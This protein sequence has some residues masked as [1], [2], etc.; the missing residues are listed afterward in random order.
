MSRDRLTAQ[1]VLHPNARVVWITLLLSGTVVAFSSL[2]VLP[3]NGRLLAPVG[4]LTLLLAVLI[5]KSPFN[6]LLVLLFVMLTTWLSQIRLLG[7]WLSPTPMIGA[8]VLVSWALRVLQRK[9]PFDFKREYWLLILF[10]ALGLLETVASVYRSD[11]AQ[12]F[13]TYLQLVLIVVLIVNLADTPGKLRQIGWVL[14]GAAF[15]LSA[16]IVLDELGWLSGGLVSQIIGERLSGETQGTLR[17]AGAWGDP[18]FTALQISLGLAFAFEFLISSRN[19]LRR[20]LLLAGIVMSIGVIVLTYSMGGLLG[21]IVMALARLALIWHA[22]SLRRRWGM[23]LLI[24]S[25]AIGLIVFSPADYRERIQEKF[26]DTTEILAAPTA[27]SLLYLGTKRGAAW[28]AA[29]T[30]LSEHPLGV[31][32]GVSQFYLMA[33]DPLG[34]LA[35][36]LYSHNA[37]LAIAVEFG[38]LGLLIFLGLL[39]RV[40]GQLRIKPPASSPDLRVMQHAL[41]VTWSGFLVQSMLLNAE[42]FKGTWI[43]LGLTLAYGD[44]A[45]SCS[46]VSAEPES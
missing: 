34:R 45:R 43:L 33:D 42:D 7:G 40:L 32:P 1:P 28:A 23:A 20:A 35:G 44:V 13:F 10:V 9:Q 24:A 5:F 30:V 3:A 27:D 38:W 17:A 36:Q 21:V 26:D 2:L 4:V 25:T 11:S 16:A 31:G 18:N 8:L 39:L 29:W 14:V 37:F 12:S 22:G 41:L 15:A 19:F 46:A 6:G